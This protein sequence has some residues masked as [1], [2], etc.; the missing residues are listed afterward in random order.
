MMKLMRSVT[1]EMKL[2]ATPDKYAN[3]SAVYDGWQGQGTA[4]WDITAIEDAAKEP[5]D[6]GWNLIMS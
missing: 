6:S 5:A 3:W 4:R 1:K 2:V